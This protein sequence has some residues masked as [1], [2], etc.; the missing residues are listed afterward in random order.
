M[1][2]LPIVLVTVAVSPSPTYKDGSQNRIQGQDSLFLR[3]NNC[4]TTDLSA[5]C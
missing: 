4:V 5:I 3:T 2:E 1:T